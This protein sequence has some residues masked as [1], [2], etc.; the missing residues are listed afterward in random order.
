MKRALGL[1]LSLLIFSIFANAQNVTTGKE[2]YRISK[3][4]ITQIKSGQN[5]RGTGFIISADGLIVTANHVVTTPE[6]NFRK[7]APNLGAVV[8]KDGVARLYHAAPISTDISDDQVNFDTALLKVD[9]SGLQSLTLGDWKEVDIGDPLT[10]IPWLPDIGMPLITGTVSNTGT[11]QTILGNKLVNTI[12]FQAPVRGGFS[13]SPLFGPNGHVV[14]IVTTK[15]Y[16]ISPDLDSLRKQLNQSSANV[17]VVL[18]GANF[19]TTVISLINTL[20]E[21]LV[22]GLGTAVDIGYAKRMQ[23]DQKKPATQH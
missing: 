10:I 8:I 23:Q 5:I 21:G 2:I 16:G 14:G 7:Y 13:G 22:S 4:G 20:D 17:S 9:I 1:V 3:N 6:S 15:L 12:M 18:Q 19:A 11:A